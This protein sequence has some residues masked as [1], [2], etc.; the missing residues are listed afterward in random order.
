MLSDHWK[1]TQLE[2]ACTE[3][4]LEEIQQAIALMLQGKLKG[5]TILKLVE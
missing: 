1:P 5:R 3:I 4:K 2:E